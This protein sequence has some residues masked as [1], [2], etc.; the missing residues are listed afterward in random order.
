MPRNHRSTT[1]SL[2]LIVVFTEEFPDGFSLGFVENFSINQSYNNELIRGVGH[3]TAIE[4]VPH[5]IVQCDISWGATH[6]YD[7]NAQ[8]ASVV[9]VNSGPQGLAD[10]DVMRVAFFNSDRGEFIAQAVGVLANQVGITAGAQASV[11]ENWSGTGI[12]CQWQR[13]LT[14]A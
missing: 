12:K 9:P 10:H 14:A 6:T 3:Q 2:A 13:E 5:G 8:Q 7:Q 11:K 1:A 4:N